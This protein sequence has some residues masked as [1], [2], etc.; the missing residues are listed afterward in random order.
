METKTN[1]KSF[2]RKF[3][4]FRKISLLNFENINIKNFNILFIKIRK[5]DPT[6]KYKINFN[7]LW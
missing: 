7:I 3:K 5:T 2:K 6:I 4:R 1:I